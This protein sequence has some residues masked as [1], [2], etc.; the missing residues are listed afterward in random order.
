MMLSTKTSPLIFRIMPTYNR[1]A[2]VPQ[3]IEYFMRQNYADKGLV[4]F[5][6]STAATRELTLKERSAVYLD[7]LPLQQASVGYGQ[8]GTH[9]GLGYEGKS[10][11]V[12]WQHCQH[13]LSTY[14]PALLAFHLRRRLGRF[15]YK[16]ERTNATY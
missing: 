16:E 6:D 1:R 11:L 9:G 15:C 4:I 7:T 13:A 2:F 3:A 12:R 10:V 5:D 14:L 8:L